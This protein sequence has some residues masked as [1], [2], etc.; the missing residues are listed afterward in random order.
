MTHDRIGS[1]IVHGGAGDF[2]DERADV[3]RAGCLR[4]VDAALDVLAGGGEALDAAQMAVRA[5]EDDPEFNA[6]VGAVLTRE[7]TIEADAALMDGRDLRFGAVAAL[8]S[9]RRPI[10]LARAVLDDGEHALLCGEGAWAFLRA[11]GH[12]PCDLEA[13]ITERARARL[14][15]ARGRAGRTVSE[16]DPERDREP[17]PGT[18]GACVIDAAGHVAAATST[19]GMT[20]KRSGRIGDTPICG[21][22]TFADDRAGAASATGEGEAILRVTMARFCADAMRRGMRAGEAA[23]EA[24]R[25]LGDQVGG[26]GGIICVDAQGRV[27]AAHNSRRMAYGAGALARG[28]HRLG[29]I[30]GLALSPHDDLDAELR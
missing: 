2:A 17:D 18:V 3:V 28:G 5:L 14:E 16:R 11:R 4:A 20:Y 9:A 27:G 13:L 29:R 25:E 10:D 21:G 24:V 15:A 26:R 12:A 19:G 23:R 6:G 1:V 30:A 7:G 8:A 22:G